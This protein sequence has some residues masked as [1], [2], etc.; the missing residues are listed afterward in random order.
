LVGGHTVRGAA[1]INTLT[2]FWPQRAARLSG[3]L[4]LVVIVGGV[5]AE[6]VVRERFLVANDA[7]ATANNI[8]ANERLFRWGFASDLIASLCV[9]PLIYLLYELLKDA[10]RHVARTAIFFSLVGTAVQSM[11]LLGHFAPLIL[12]KRGVMLGV[13][14][15]LLRAQS[16]MAL[17]LQG[18]G[19]A[20]ALAFFG[21][22]ML[23]RGYLIARSAV[24]PRAIGVALM[25]EGLAY[26]ANS[27]IDFVAPALANTVLPILMATGLAEVALCLWLLGMGVNVRRWQELRALQ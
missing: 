25:I 6:L 10:N 14:I 27:L 22:T 19:Y 26:W 2:P 15:D 24:V 21:G 1:L 8:L 23:C 9:V 16:Y 4:Y 7:V 13:P 18:I 3:F 17:Q 11:A 12:L 5:I 20:V